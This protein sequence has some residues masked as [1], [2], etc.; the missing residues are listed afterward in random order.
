MVSLYYNKVYN[1]ANQTSKKHSSD[2]ASPPK[3]IRFINK[4]WKKTSIEFKINGYQTSFPTTSLFDIIKDKEQLIGAE[5]VFYYDQNNARV[6]SLSEEID[7]EWVAE[8]LAILERENQEH[9]YEYGSVDM[10]V[11]DVDQNPDDLET[12]VTRSGLRRIITEDTGTQT[13]YVYIEKPPI[14]V[15]RDCTPEVKNTCV[16]V[17]VKCGISTAMATVAVQAVC[18]E[19]YHHQC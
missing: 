4:E 16:K 12:S 6:C 1:I 5:K 3:S 9:E 19:L 8:Q 13:E 18:E 7:E 10:D 17:S 14:R 15:A 11:E 2:S